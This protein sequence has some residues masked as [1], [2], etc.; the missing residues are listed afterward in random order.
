MNKTVSIRILSN[1]LIFKL[2]NLV[3]CFITLFVLCIQLQL[4]NRERITLLFLIRCC[5]SKVIETEFENSF[6]LCN[7]AA[8]FV[9]VEKFL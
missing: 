7:T 3:L 9:N 5:F 8:A 1:M 2:K 4:N 6:N